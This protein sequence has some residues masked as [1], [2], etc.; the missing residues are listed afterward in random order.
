VP[1]FGPVPGLALLAALIPGS[2]SA[3][4][5]AGPTFTFAGYLQTQYNR[6]SVGD[7]SH[8]RV[9]FRRAIVGV[10]AELSDR[11]MGE[12]QADI[13]P[14][15]LSERIEIRDAYLRYTGLAPRGLTFTFGNQKLP[16]ARSVLVSSARRGF[17]ERPVT[18]E[19]A[20][21]ASGR[22]IAFK[23][24]GRDVDHLLLWSAAVASVHHAPTSDQIRLDGLAT[25][26]ADW[27]EGVMLVG[28][29]EWHPRGFVPLEQG[30]FEV[31]KTIATIGGGAYYW[32]NDGDNNLFTVDGAS[33]SHS[34][35]DLD[36]ATGLELSGGVRAPRLS[37][38]AELHRI[39]GR[40]IDPAFTGGLY[41][42]GRTRLIKSSIE[43]GYMLAPPHL[44]LLGGVESLDVDA[45]DSVSWRPAAGVNWYVYR[46]RLKFQFMQRETLNEL[47]VRGVHGHATYVQAQIMF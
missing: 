2:L 16:F 6:L 8:D 34:A 26:R 19:R 43:A 45:Y 23:V 25:S 27:N 37:I 32:V 3:Q 11:W 28:R 42:A 7:T 12:L 47:G 17:V 30:A 33:T 36:R 21:G 22:A 13:A 20:Y 39:T 41:H 4:T 24:D 38:D 1:R 5:P 31:K 29:T 46:H 9:I 44:E 14:V 15:S 18:G 10:E 35:A 40:T